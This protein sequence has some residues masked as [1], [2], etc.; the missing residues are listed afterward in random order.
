MPPFGIKLPGTDR[1]SH[2]MPGRLLVLSN[3][4]GE[5][6]IALRV[7]L[8]LRQRCPQL[9]LAVL[10]LVGEGSAFAAAEQA[11]ALR[12]I[13]PRRLLPSG[14]FSNQSLSG[15]L[16]DLAAGVVG[17]SWRQWRLVRRWGLR[18]DPVLAVGDL[19]PLLL[20]WGSGA[21][22]G[23]IG[24]PKSDYTWR[25][26]PGSA[27]VAALYHRLKGSEWDPW[28]WALMGRARC[29]LVALRDGLTARGLQ[30]HGVRALAPGNPM[31]DGLEGSPLPVALAAHRR[32]VLLGGSRMPEALGNLERLLL[33]LDPWA[34]RPPGDRHAAGLLVLAPTGSRPSPEDW[35]PLL[36][37]LGYEPAAI[38]DG[39]G[40]QAAWCRGSV[41]L[42]IGS[43]GFGRWASWGEVGI[44]AAGTATEQLV[45]LGVPCLSLPGPGPQFK[46]GFAQRQSR[47][48]GG[49]VGVCRSAAELA[50]RLELLWREPSLRRALGR[51][52]RRRMGPPGGSAAL[53]EL[54]QRHL[55]DAASAAG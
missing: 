44:A 45:G 25:S 18:G 8:A 23:F 29:R 4:H 12:R 33:A 39:T 36:Q 2:K 16:R 9:E 22:Y 55:V 5:D 37:R 14:G 42:L 30:R 51:I 53:A 24:T 54:V 27:G 35:Q 46:L 32:L 17:L 28:E 34:R 10:P 21:P 43:G 47:L 52:G 13:G 1:I 6:L 3:G 41:L 15:L 11:G 7:L 20:A 26:G 48:L 40:A 50:D 31:M 49:A 19:L 38:P